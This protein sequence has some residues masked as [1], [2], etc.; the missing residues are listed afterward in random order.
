MVEAVLLGG[1]GPAQF[2]LHLPDLLLKLGAQVGLI[3]RF[4][5]IQSFLGCC[6]GLGDKQTQSYE[7]KVNDILLNM[8]TPTNLFSKL[9]LSRLWF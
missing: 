1:A 7:I 8:C 3:G 4:N 6:L 5:L 9:F 2:P